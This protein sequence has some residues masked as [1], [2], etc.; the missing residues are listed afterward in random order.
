MEILRPAGAGERETV[1]ISPWPAKNR[2]HLSGLLGFLSV[3]DMACTADPERNAA[4]R[5]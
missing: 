3:P 4:P 5:H 2:K 1:V